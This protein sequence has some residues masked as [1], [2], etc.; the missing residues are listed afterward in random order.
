MRFEIS[1]ASFLFGA[2]TAGKKR[3]FKSTK[4]IKTSGVILFGRIIWKIM[5]PQ[6]GIEKFF[7]MLPREMKIEWKKKIAM[8]R[9]MGGS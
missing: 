1:E 9:D 7:I 5:N 6:R 8:V 4:N 3:C 2:K